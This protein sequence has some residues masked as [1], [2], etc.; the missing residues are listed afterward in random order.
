MTDN[1]PDL[2]HISFTEDGVVKLNLDRPETLRK[3]WQSMQQ[4]K[5]KEELGEK[6][7]NKEDLGDLG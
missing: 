2:Q 3:L 4:F 1:Q 5:P 6:M 7:I